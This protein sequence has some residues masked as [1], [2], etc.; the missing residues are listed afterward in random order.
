MGSNFWVTFA[1][2]PEYSGA[3]N[4]VGDQQQTDKLLPDVDIFNL[5]NENIEEENLL[6]QNLLQSKV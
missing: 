5:H 6:V 1:T 3:L 4:D 2:Y